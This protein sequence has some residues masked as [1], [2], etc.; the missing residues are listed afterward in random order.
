MLK[1]LEVQTALVPSDCHCMD[2]NSSSKYLS[3]RFKTTWAWVN[4]KRGFIFGW[5]IPLTILWF[6]CH[7]SICQVDNHLQTHAA[8]YSF[9]HVNLY[10]EHLLICFSCGDNPHKMLSTGFAIPLGHFQK[11]GP[12]RNTKT[13]SHKPTYLLPWA[14]K[15]QMF[16]TETD[17]CM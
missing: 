5:T 17:A 2:K 10:L 8:T 6:W 13:C 4:D 7:N 9:T 11:Y 15:W 3:Y 14:A 1:T 16:I 12:N